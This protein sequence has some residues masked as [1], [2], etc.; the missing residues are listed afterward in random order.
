MTVY[1]DRICTYI[2]NVHYIIPQQEWET[3]FFSLEVFSS[4]FADMEYVF[5]P[6]PLL[7]GLLGGSFN[8]WLSFEN[9]DN[10]SYLALQPNL[11]PEVYL[12]WAY[13]KLGN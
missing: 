11:Q 6:S 4:V 8:L 7:G 9:E 10:V 3:I 5:Y 2:Y 13:W 12:K 1:Q